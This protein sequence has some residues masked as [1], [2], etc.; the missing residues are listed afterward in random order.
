MIKIPLQ[1]FGF[2]RTL[3]RKLLEK[4]DV[5]AKKDKFLAKSFFVPFSQ[6]PCRAV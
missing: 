5:F 1:R 6:K 3:R 4:G 2:H